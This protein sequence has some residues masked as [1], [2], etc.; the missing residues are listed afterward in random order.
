MLL[1]PTSASRSPAGDHV[2]IILIFGIAD[3]GL[4]FAPFSS[5]VKSW[6]KNPVV[7]VSIAKVSWLVGTRVGVGVV[8]VDV[9]LR[10]FD[11]VSDG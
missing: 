11:G 8:E 6:G 3:I 2:G 5:E 1:R 4:T 9:A 10:V 7:A